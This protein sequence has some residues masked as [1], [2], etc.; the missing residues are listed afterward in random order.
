M[1]G[2]KVGWAT[3]CVAL[4]GVALGAPGCGKKGGGKAAP[5]ALSI[6]IEPVQDKVRGKAF[7]LRVEDTKIVILMALLNRHL[8]LFVEE[9]I[10]YGTQIRVGDGA[11]EELRNQQEIDVTRFLAGLALQPNSGASV[12]S[13]PVSIQINDGRIGTVTLAREQLEGGGW[14]PDGVF[15]D[16]SEGHP[17]AFVDGAPDDGGGK[18]LQLQ[19]DPW[20]ILGPGRVVRD[21]DW[22]ARAE[23]AP[24]PAG[25]LKCDY[26]GRGTFHSV[27]VAFYDK[28]VT[29]VD[30][31]TGARV[32]QGRVAVEQ[33]CPDRTSFDD[34]GAAT[35]TAI[36]AASGDV[37]A[38]LKTQ[39]GGPAPGG[40]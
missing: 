40:G 1:G 8:D 17:S 37:D 34:V 38:W 27:N 7:Y 36:S 9:Q 39:L 3:V 22:I 14:S 10:P 15:A 35:T 26:E 5:P 32:A 18:T 4:A 16:A 28:V 23:P 20:T 11:F 6:A 13:I 29:I 12:V 33:R 30:R 24:E 2:H 25:T 31:R 19:G 21:I